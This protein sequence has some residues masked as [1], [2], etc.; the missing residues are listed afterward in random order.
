MI[1]QKYFIFLFFITLVLMFYI[2]IKFFKFY[3]DVSGT[4]AIILFTFHTIRPETAKT[5]VNFFLE[6]VSVN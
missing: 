1:K 3:Q 4:L 6:I 5:F 2:N